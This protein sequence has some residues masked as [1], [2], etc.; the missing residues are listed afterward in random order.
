MDTHKKPSFVTKY[1]L[2]FV[3]VIIAISLSL[4]FH[5]LP[6]HK[7][8]S[9]QDQVT[10]VYFADN[11]TPAH[12]KIINLFNEKYLG[13]IEI[14][15]VNLPFTKFNTNERKELIARTL[16]NRTSR[17]DIFAV[18]QIWV[19][20][21][22]KWAE[23]LSR[24]FSNKDRANI[25]THALSTCYYEN[26]LVGVPLHIDIGIMYYRRDIIQNFPNYSELVRKLKSSITWG[27]F[28]QL[29]EQYDSSSPFYIFQA[30]KYEGL[31]CNF[32]E[33]LGGHDGRLFENNILQLN[34]PYARES[35]QLMVD[36]IHK[37]SITPEIVETF[38]ESAS[39]AYALKYNVPFFRG[40]PGFM[41]EIMTYPE[42]STKVNLLEIAALPHFQGHK[43]ASVIGG[44]NLMISKHSAKKEEAVLFLKFISSEEAQTIFFETAGYLPILNTIYENESFINANPNLL[45]LKKLL[46]RG[47]HR[48][49]HPNYTKMSNILSSFI[50]KALKRELSV[51][52]AL[53][54]TSEEILLRN[55]L[56][57]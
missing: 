6:F 44:W 41:K 17:I 53:S 21:F 36:L 25:L 45:Y 50:H 46:D 12:K 40:W 33:T 37:Y 18:D 5:F 13:Q 8:A 30:D 16:R 31:V 43:P 14:I 10:K 19:S 23:P 49:S 42:G 32:L 34:Q 4:L 9:S 54:Q 29:S 2:V 47:I 35:C 28:I 11:I 7:Q 27:E 1:N 52:E 38:N 15:P 26:T 57:K 56:H 48:P 24:Y 22:A 51:E 3:L 20:R 39:Y 55:V